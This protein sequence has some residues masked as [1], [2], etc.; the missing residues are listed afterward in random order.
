M[1]HCFLPIF[2]VQMTI[3]SAFIPLAGCGGADVRTGVDIDGDPR[4]GAIS[5]RLEI[6]EVAHIDDEKEDTWEVMLSSDETVW[7]EQKKP[8][9]C[10]AAC[11]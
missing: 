10:W 7:N 11:M 6:V 3:C 9:Y 1:K 4:F 5:N 2:L 8:D